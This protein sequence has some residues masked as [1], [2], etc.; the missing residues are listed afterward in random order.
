LSL[1]G[2]DY[3]NKK[4]FIITGITQELA[5]DHILR[6]RNLFLQYYPGAIEQMDYTQKTITLNESLFRAYPAANPEA[7][8][9]KTDVFFILADEFDHHTRRQQ[10]DMMSVITPYR[11]KTDTLIVLNSTTKN[12]E[13]LYADMDKQWIE[14]LKTLD[15][16]KPDIKYNDL[17]NLSQNNSVGYVQRIREQIKHHYFLLEFDYLWGLGQGK[18]YTQKEIDEVKDDRTFPGEF[19]LQYEGLIGNIF[20]P[21]KIDRAVALGEQYKNIPVNQY[22]LHGC[23][24]DPGFGS[25][26]SA[27]VLTEHLKEQ[28]KIRVLYAAQF[29]HPNPEDIADLC[30]D[31]HRKYQNTWFF[32]DG[33]NRGFITQLKVDFGESVNWEKSQEVS[34]QSNRVLPVNF[35]TDHKQ[36]LTHLHLLINKEYLAIPKEYDKLI[37]SLRTAIASEYTLDKEATSYDDLLDAFRLSLKAYKVD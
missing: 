28:S 18:I 3:R 2:N 16:N 15:M 13:G 21:L 6:L 29:D 7:P 27:I 9:G 32:V 19:C 12:P 4:A 26:K 8:R 37:L 34:P 11:P 14:F 23:G 30:F 20:S 35:M 10:E 5:N 36:M 33:A 25:S 24:V 31:L 1:S 22:T 17:F